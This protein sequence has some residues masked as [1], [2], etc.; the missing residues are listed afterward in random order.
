MFMALKIAPER[1]Y[2]LQGL[3]RCLLALGKTGE[4]ATQLG[5]ARTLWR[6]MNATRRI[7]EIDELLAMTSDGG[8]A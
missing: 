6:Q 1:A 7:A 4:G 8:S 2:A 3:G 5:D